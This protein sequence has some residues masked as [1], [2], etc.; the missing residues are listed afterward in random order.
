MINGIIKT[1]LK[2]YTDKKGSVFRAIRKDDDG[3]V[4][5]EE[6]YFSVVNKG[7]IKGWKMHQ[8]MTLNLVV[9]IGSVLMCCVDTRKKSSTYNN[10]NKFFLSQDPYFR[11]TV[12]PKVWFAFKGISDEANLICNISDFIHDANEVVL[13]ELREFEVDWSTK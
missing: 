2:K 8:K 6:V 5:F 12:P 7:V 4:D 9:P 10:V 1:K 13:K 3:Y 11:L